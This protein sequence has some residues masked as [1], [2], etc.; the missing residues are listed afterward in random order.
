MDE[1]VRSGGRQDVHDGSGAAEKLQSAVSGGNMMMGAEAETEEVPQFVVASTEPPC[2]VRALEPAHW[3]VAAFDAT[4]ILLQSVVEVTAGAVLHV[5]PQRRTDRTR[6]AVVPVGGHPFRRDAGD[7]LGR[8]EE[9]F[10][11][12][13][14]A[15]LAE[16]HVDQ[17]PVAVNGAIEIAPL[18][19]HLDISLVDVPAT[20]NFAAAV[21]TQTF[22]Q[23]RR[24][25]WLRVSRGAA[26]GAYDDLEMMRKWSAQFAA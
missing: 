26:G 9:R 25:N 24:N 5:L 11:G 22:R 2:R 12:N 13:H 16:H 17:R 8:S 1:E 14:V 7:C 23:C 21:A 3:L 18:S 15:V 4:M 6:V 19:V 20:T 10:R